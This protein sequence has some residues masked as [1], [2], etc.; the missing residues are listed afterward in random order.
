M[1]LT[2]GLSVRRVALVLAF[3]LAACG[4]DRETLLVYSPHGKELLQAAETAFEEAR[5]G[6]DVQ[7]IDLGS[8]AAYDRVR[9]DWIVLGPMY[10]ASG[11][12]QAL[13]CVW[14]GARQILIPA[15]E[16]AHALAFLL[17]AVGE[18]ELR[19]NAEVL[20]NLCGRGDKD[21]DTYFN[22]FS[23]RRS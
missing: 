7:W 19:R 15:F 23:G 8:Q 11:T 12:F 17:K 21:L 2:T 5:P 16:P 13:L 3:V 6:V 10:H 22:H 4:D 20:V 9:G 1:R 18:G 14:V